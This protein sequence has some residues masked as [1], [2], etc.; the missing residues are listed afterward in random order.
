MLDSRDY[1]SSLFWH[2]IKISECRA[3]MDNQLYVKLELLALVKCIVA[4]YS[5]L[6]PDFYKAFHLEQVKSWYVIW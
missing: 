4:L 3:I 6:F 5:L 1:F 2:A